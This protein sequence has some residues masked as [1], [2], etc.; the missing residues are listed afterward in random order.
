MKYTSITLSSDIFMDHN[1]YKWA[2]EHCPSFVSVTQVSEE[3]CEEVASPHR[4]RH[5]V[6][7]YYVRFHFTDERDASL[8]AMRWSN[9]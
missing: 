2:E 8:F 7:E 5:W 4:P 3:V 9:V 1:P 6:L